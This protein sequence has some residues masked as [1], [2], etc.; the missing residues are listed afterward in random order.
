MEQ[1]EYILLPH[2]S[3]YEPVAVYTKLTENELNYSTIIIAT[4]GLSELFVNEI[5]K[6]VIINNNLTIN[7]LFMAYKESRIKHDK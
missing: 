7:G 4:G 2:T 3:T 1:C 5:S 6:K